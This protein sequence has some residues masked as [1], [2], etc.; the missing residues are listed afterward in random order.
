[1]KSRI[2]L[3]LIFTP[4]ISL[5]PL[6][7]YSQ[8]DLSLYNM[9]HVPQR[10]SQNP[11]FI[12]EQNSYF[13]IPFLSGIH[14][15][16]A[17]PFAYN[18][19]IAK[20]SNDSLTLKIDHAIDKISKNDH[21]H[22]YTDLDILS[23]GFK[24]SRERFYL[25]FNVRQRVSQDMLIPENL[26]YLVW[27]GNAS[28]EIFGKNV[29][30]APKVN[31][32]VYNEFG[33][34]FS[35]YLMDDKLTYGVRLKYLS[36]YFNLNTKKST[37]NVLTDSSTFKILLKSDIEI[38]TSGLDQIDT[39][40]D[41]R[42]I[43]IA[44]PGNNGIG[45]DFGLNYQVNEQ[46]NVNA[47][48]LD[49]GFISWKSRT[50]SLVSQDPGEEFEFQGY[51]LGEFMNLFNDA[52]S[53][54]NELLDSISDYLQFDSIYN[55]KY[56]SKLPVR[57]NIGGTYTLN[58]I[59]HFNLLMNGI[60]W[61]HHLSPALSI[62]YYYNPRPFVGLIL[63]YNLF[64]KQY[65]NFGG[66]VSINGGSLHFYIVSDNIPG[67]IFYKNTNNTSIQFGINI[68]PGWKKQNKETQDTTND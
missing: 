19:I 16:D 20:D 7:V 46:I 37:A 62:S 24:I 61:N 60:S 57:V 38:Q 9:S 4:F 1:M 27:Y 35:G 22:I 13:G 36:G 40:F 43:K 56:K 55:V 47:S 3:L 6:M 54:G 14:L 64:N 44:F 11:A 42:F 18:D 30:I 66:G 33:V 52:E 65:T 34:S 58:D 31:F 28:P 45:F 49:L 2:V 15:T 39:Y 21:V 29:N 63:S 25:N 68:F 23:F 59:H 50:L 51:R 26:C 48:V 10:I 67:L 17:N 12:P 8:H 5:I 41:Q 53:I 32:S